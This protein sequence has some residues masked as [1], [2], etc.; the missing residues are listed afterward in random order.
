MVQRRGAAS[1]SMRDRIH[2]QNAKQNAVMMRAI[3]F[4]F[5]IISSGSSDLFTFGCFILCLFENLSRDKLE[6]M[7]S[8]YKEYNPSQKSL[9]TLR[10]KPSPASPLSMLL[11]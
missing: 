1:Y 11:Q 4:L 8:I 7:P 3:F 6:K 9:A 10:R 5:L 2:V